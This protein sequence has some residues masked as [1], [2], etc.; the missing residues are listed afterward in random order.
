LSI[1]YGN[2]NWLLIF[3]DNARRVFL[4]LGSNGKTILGLKEGNFRITLG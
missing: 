4:V 2:E 3:K 1:F